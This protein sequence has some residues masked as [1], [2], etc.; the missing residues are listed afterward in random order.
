MKSSFCHWEQAGSNCGQQPLQWAL[1]LVINFLV[2]F[3]GLFSFPRKITLELIEE[4]LVSSSGQS[5][6]RNS[7]TATG[8]NLRLFLQRFPDL[9][10]HP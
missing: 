3:M 4:M 5:A 1:S 9:C 7:N 2:I 8:E 10:Y 6:V